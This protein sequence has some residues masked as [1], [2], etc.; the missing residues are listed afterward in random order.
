MLYDTHKIHGFE[1]Q[2]SSKW[3]IDQMI[4]IQTLPFMY[5]A[6]IHSPK[7]LMDGPFDTA[8]INARCLG[9]M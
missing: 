8:S 2:I 5:F 6:I 7:F 9:G 4:K 1:K 3:F